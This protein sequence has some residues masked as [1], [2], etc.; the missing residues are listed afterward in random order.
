M[1]VLTPI[2]DAD[3]RAIARAHALG[4]VVRVDGIPAGSV[5]SNFALVTCNGK[6]FLRIYEEQGEE[7]ARAEAA[8]LARLASAG[9]PTGAPIA[10]ADGGGSVSAVG[11][12]PVAI[13]PWRPGVHRCQASVTGDDCRRVGEALA[14]VH[15]AGEGA[16]RAAG[17]FRYEDL[18]ERTARIAAATDATLAAQ[19]PRLRAKLEEWTARRDPS[20]P[21]G[22]VHGDLFRDNVLWNA[23]GSISALLDFESASDGVLA[24]DLMVTALAWC[25]G[26]ALDLA[27]VR[28]MTLGYESV[29]PLEARERR[30]LAAEACAAAVR[31]TITRVTDYAM[32]VTEGPRVIKDWRRFAARL[33][34]IEALGADGLARA[35]WG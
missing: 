8:L 2:S 29:R 31:F 20:L 16:P 4:D 33:A 22:L 11:G 3:A 9:V 24:Y 5:N 1:A 10:R 18:V 30:G 25:Y 21:R 12:K 28:A 26:D 34:A 7:G 35:I 15:R 32:R 27:L 23:D 13:F 6:Y 19:S 17:R 14:R